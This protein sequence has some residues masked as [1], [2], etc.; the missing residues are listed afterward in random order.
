MAVL[1][2]FEAMTERCKTM[3]TKEKELQAVVLVRMLQEFQSC[4]MFFFAKM[5]GVFHLF[6]ENKK[7]NLQSDIFIKKIGSHLLFTHE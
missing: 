2:N 6:M 5:V 7:Q 1:G 3:K 4:P